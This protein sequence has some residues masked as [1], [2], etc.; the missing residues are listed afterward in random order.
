MIGG[1]KGKGNMSQIAVQVGVFFE[2][3]RFFLGNKGK[4]QKISL[5][6]PAMPKVERP[7]QRNMEGKKKTPPYLRRLE[8]AVLKY[9][10]NFLMKIEAIFPDSR[11]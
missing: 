1:R 6:H 11:T 4:E 7:L 2:K 9:N 8:G 3:M 10:F 5:I